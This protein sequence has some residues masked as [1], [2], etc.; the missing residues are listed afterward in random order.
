M[1]A[2]PPLK[3]HN[4]KLKNP[5]NPNKNPPFFVFLEYYISLDIYVSSSLEE[6]LILV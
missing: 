4:K 6:K 1:P 5:E 3:K 2:R